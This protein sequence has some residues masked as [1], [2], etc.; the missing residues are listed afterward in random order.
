MFENLANEIEV[1]RP[2]AFK[3]V[4]ILYLD[5]DPVDHRLMSL[6]LRS[7][8]T[9]LD[10]TITYV[11]DIEDARSVLDEG[12][13][14]IFVMDNQMPCSPNFHETLARLGKIDPRTKIVVVSSVIDEDIFHHMDHLERKP[15]A[16][17]DKSHLRQRIKSGLFESLLARTA[18]EA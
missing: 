10:H 7:K 18:P 17:V 9:N 13:V 2:N 8:G 5:D 4:S 14:D 3:T 11:F 6:A 16:I 15:D 1:L 12:F